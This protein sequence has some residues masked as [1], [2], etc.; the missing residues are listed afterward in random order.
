MHGGLG[1]PMDLLATTKTSDTACRRWKNKKKKNS[2][3]AQ[4]Q[5]Q[6]HDQ[7]DRPGPSDQQK[8]YN[9][10]KPGHYAKDCRL[11]CKEGQGRFN[12]C[13]M[14]SEDLEALQEEL[15]QEGFLRGS[16][17]ATTGHRFRNLWTGLFCLLYRLH[18]QY[19][20]LPQMILP[21]HRNDP[22][23]LRKRLL[24]RTLIR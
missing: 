1:E 4:Q 3:P 23:H 10:G 21:F 2:R 20:R 12:V 22:A 6:Q 24:K 18:V 11:P 7:K 16:V 15:E 19:H 17:K 8:C 13:V 14:S 5:P 9:C